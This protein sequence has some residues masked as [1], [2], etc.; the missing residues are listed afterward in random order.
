[1]VFSKSEVE[2]IISVL[3]ALLITDLTDQERL[4]VAGLVQKWRE[5][6]KSAEGLH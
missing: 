3:E 1:M 2:A 5:P 6:K 4:V